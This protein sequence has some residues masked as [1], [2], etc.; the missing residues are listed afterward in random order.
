MPTLAEMDVARDV[1]DA[2][3]IGLINA[4]RTL[5]QIA[6]EMKLN[7]NT[8]RHRAKARGLVADASHQRSGVTP[9]RPARIQK[10]CKC[11]GLC[12]SVPAAGHR[13]GADLTCECGTSWH[14][15]QRHPVECPVGKRPE[16]V[17]YT[18]AQ[19]AEPKEF[20]NRGHPWTNVYTNPQGKDH[21]RVC[22]RSDQ[23][24]STQRRREKRR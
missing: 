3:M 8:V 4:G 9:T 20:C 13:F 5:R 12:Q 1:R 18:C 24:K 15:M 21:C 23:A 2:H 10:P 22:R 6:D 14:V 11:D 17:S 19:P 16:C 7:L